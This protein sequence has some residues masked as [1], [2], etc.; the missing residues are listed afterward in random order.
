MCGFGNTGKFF[1]SL[2]QLI[3]KYLF[4]FLN[5]KRNFDKYNYRLK[6]LIA[7]AIGKKSYFRPKAQNINY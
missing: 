1:L 7:A 4:K 2:K 3:K 6:G 5:N